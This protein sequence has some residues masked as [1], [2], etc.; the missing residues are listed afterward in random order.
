MIGSVTA[1]PWE[2]RYEGWDPDE[3]PLRE[4]L[5]TVANGYLGTR[6]AVPER[7]AGGPHYPGTYLAGV[8]DRRT[9]IVDGH[10][11][12][13]E[14]LV[15]GPNWLPLRFRVEDGPWF[16]PGH[17]DVELVEHHQVL[18]LRRGVLV[19]WFRFRDGAGRTTAVR[20]ERFVSM[21]D[22]HLAVLR[23]AFR[24]EDWTGN[25]T[26]F[27]GLDGAVG[28]DG[29]DRYRELE[30]PH[31]EPPERDEPRAGT[32][33]LRTRTFQSRLAVAMACRTRTTVGGVPVG[34]GTFVCPGDGEV[35]H[36]LTVALGP[37]VT[38]EVEKRVAVH[39][40][41]DPAISEPGDAV[42]DRLERAEAVADLE[43]GHRLAW[44]D[45]WR[46]F[47]I[48]PDGDP[49]LH[50][51]VNVHLF[52]LIGVASPHTV[53]LDVGIPARG[54]HGEA[55]RG[56]IF[57]DE[58]FVFPTLTYHAPEIAAGLLRYRSRRL[59]K[60]MHLAS[61][62]GHRGAQFPW[63]SGSD[64][65]EESQVVHLNPRSGRW[66]PDLSHRQRHIGLA[67]AVNVWRY[68][69][70]TDDLDFLARHGAE[71][72]VEV[73]RYFADLAVEDPLT[74]RSHIEGVMGP[75]EFHDA[76]PNRDGPALRDN[77]YTNV[78]VAWLA[79][80]A[81][82]VLDP[83][84]DRQRERLVERLGITRDELDRWRDLSHRI[85][86]PTHAGVISQFD[87]YERLAELDW[88]GYRERYG[89]IHRLDRILEA[90]GDSVI[91]Y[92]A[93]KQADVLML[94]FLFSYEELEVVFER[95]GV[96]FDED[97]LARTIDYYL[98]RT[99]HGSTLSAV[100][101]A[102]VLARTDRR[103]SAEL[104]A[105]VLR[106]DLRDV[107]GGTTREG[108]HLGAM[109]GSIDLL[110]RGYSGIEVRD[111][112]LR[113]KPSLPE[114]IDRVRF[115]IHVRGRWIDVE[116]TGDTVQLSSE[117]TPRPPLG[118][119]CR[120]ERCELGSGET[121]TFERVRAQDG[122]EPFRLIDGVG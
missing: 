15:N 35:G 86:I 83:L 113:F 37:G 108:I 91:N 63:Q 95:L 10:E 41:R 64:G 29:V 33:R 92:K 45:L 11:V 100:V 43:V 32:A 54:L 76:D 70:V 68:V 71:L 18:E 94:F 6:G 40:G 115:P 21:A 84:P 73:L 99:S 65:R 50:L 49:D 120:G 13:N 16:H 1:D 105:Q 102:W 27:A 62:D 87:G 36:E 56:H 121:H 51:A 116:L 24:A 109:A 98:A 30:G 25:L 97:V 110:F 112:V 96:A 19:R 77:A 103:R 122:T 104:F 88:V 20:Q 47:R 69:E 89:D 38:V 66:L 3:E 48:D 23:T 52:H 79:D 106:S 81:R 101:H 39:T 119:E 34:P 42:V 59:D 72:M 2:L 58:L 74:G 117:R 31:L 44:D 67:V 75:D 82:T 8:Y 22:H 61:L 107:Q 111:G 90:E 57:W 60:A 118:I 114:G 12:E 78:L 14:S 9:A 53:D 5:C 4:A 7:P 55:Y 26:V 93:S 85:S 80:R 28:N 17:P 46:R